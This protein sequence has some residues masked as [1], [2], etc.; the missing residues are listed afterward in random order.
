MNRMTDT[1]FSKHYLPLQSVMR[2]YPGGIQQLV[3]TH[4]NCNPVVVVGEGVFLGSQKS[5]CQVLSKFQFLGW[6]G[7]WGY[8]WV[9]KT[10]SAKFCP[11]FNF[12]GGGGGIFFGSQKSKCSI[13]LK[14][15]C[16]GVGEGGGYSLVVKTQIS[17]F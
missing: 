11:N 1:H 17:Q 7:E 4:S 16:S 14:F 9:V 6:V 10:Q 13:L 12:F 15:K 3:S 5:K 2:R 8:S